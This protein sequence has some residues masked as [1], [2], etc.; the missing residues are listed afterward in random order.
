M[1]IYLLF[2]INKV[3]NVL[4]FDV[5]SFYIGNPVVAKYKIRTERNLM[6]MILFVLYIYSAFLRPQISKNLIFSN[7]KMFVI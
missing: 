1:I 4:F 7:C 3:I 6:S 5:V 2:I